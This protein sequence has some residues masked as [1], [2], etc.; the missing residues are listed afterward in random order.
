M[1]VTLTYA[2]KLKGKHTLALPLLCARFLLRMIISLLQQK[3]GQFHVFDSV[4]GPRHRVTFPAVPV[5]RLA[6]KA[7]L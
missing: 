5:R 4:S 3:Q 7:I 2:P 6:P 1:E